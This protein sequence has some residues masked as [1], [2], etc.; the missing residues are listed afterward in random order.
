MAKHMRRILAAF[1][2]VAMLVA[3]SVSSLAAP[4]QEEEVQE[5]VVIRQLTIASTEEFL[6]FAQQCRLDSYSQNLEVTLT[7]DIDLEGTDFSGIPIFCGSFEGGSHVI[8]GF[9]LEQS[10]SVQGLFRYLTDTAQVKNLHVRGQVN[11]QGSQTQI[12]GFVG[13]NAGKIENCSFSGSVTGGDQIGGLVGTNT[14][15]GI[16]ENSRAQGEVA[17]AHFVG[18]ICGENQGVIR[19][20][21]NNAKVNTTAKQNDIDL[22]QITMDS[23]LNTETISTVTDIGGIAGSSSGVIRNCANWADVGYQ[24]IGYNIGGIVG[25][26]SG[27]VSGCSNYGRVFG[28]KEVGGIAGQ[29]EPATLI[30]YSVDTLQIL[31][32]Q[33]NALSALTGRATGNA[34]SNVAN[35]TGKI[36]ALQDYADS[37]KDAVKTLIPSAENPNLPDMDTIMAAQNTLTNSV[38]GMNNTMNGIVTSLQGTVSGLSRDLQAV[39]SQVSAMGQTLNMASENLGGTFTDVSDEDTPEQTTGKVELCGNYGTV[40]ADMNAGGI[41]GAMALENDLDPEDDVDLAGEESLNFEGKLRSVVLDCTNQGIVTANKQN[42][43]GIVGWQSLGL[44]RQCQNTGNLEC[45]NTD[46]VGGIA[47][48]SMG[49]IRNS[50]S[51]SEMAGKNYV[52]GIAGSGVVVSDCHSII[53][54]QAGTEK[55]GG[56]LGYGDTGYTDVEDPIVGNLYTSL[57]E[58]IGGIDGISYAG[59]AEPMS[60]EELMDQEA[61]PENFQSLSVTFVFEDGTAQVLQLQPGAPLLAGKIPALPEKEGYIGRWD[62]LEQADLRHITFDMTFQAVYTPVVTTLQSGQIRKNGQPILLLQGIYPEEYPFQLEPLSDVMALESWGF[63]LP[64]DG[65]TE[66]LRHALP[67]GYAAGDVL[68]EVK[69]SATGNYHAREFAESGSYIVFAVE[70]EDVA[71]RITAAPRDYSLYYYIG[72]GVLALAALITVMVVARKK[73]GSAPKPSA[74]ETEEC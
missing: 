52:G 70:T 24:Q 39:A 61:L 31:K 12:G 68:L 13:S 28:R 67:E 4:A 54:L 43:G 5:E 62:G 34:Q 33:M 41:V 35:V 7:V 74:P 10:G 65:Q 3:M 59:K 56:V 29:M 17:G 40:Q 72:G 25:S 6:T 51:R 15:T 8:S 46:Y 16:I 14:V 36:A 19:G 42:A 26:Q 69:N 73:K 63:T 64:E 21:T 47:G 50:S 30:E 53:L 20:C 18:G 48:R 11:G 58:D 66:K 23:L 27:Y 2:C 37:A 38:Q 45:A 22:T 44:V 32:E 55:V 9:C 60:H 57:E 71:F 49:Y 1:L